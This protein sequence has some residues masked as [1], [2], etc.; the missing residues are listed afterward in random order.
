MFER[1]TL[2]GGTD[3]CIR[4]GLHPAITIPKVERLVEKP[5][6][7]VVP[8]QSQGQPHE[9]SFLRHSSYSGP[10]AYHDERY[11]KIDHNQHHP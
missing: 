9:A 2:Y 6:A 7:L 4:P 11:E 5:V 8:D 1:G 3:F 10:L